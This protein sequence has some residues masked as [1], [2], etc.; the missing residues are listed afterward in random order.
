MRKAVIITA[1][2]I[3]LVGCA[4]N[5]PYGNY[6]AAPPAYNHA[7]A[8]DTV[9]HMAK[10]YP[11]AHTQ[12][13]LMQPF[14]D[15]YGKALVEGLRSRGY[16]V[17]E[18]VSDGKTEAHTPGVRS[19]GQGIPLHYLVDSLSPN[20]DL[21]RVTLIVGTNQFSRAYVQQKNGTVVPAGSWSRKE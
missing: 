12:L 19:E 9:S 16:S 8:L 7:M 6:A 10:Q 4:S 20:A 5:P 15:N 3:C 17:R 18:F 1:I 2:A 14:D 11:P 13:H 21:Y